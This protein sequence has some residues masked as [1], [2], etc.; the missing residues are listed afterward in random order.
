MQCGPALASR[1]GGAAAQL[2]C[3]RR[4]VDLTGA[5]HS[6]CLSMQPALVKTNCPG[7]LP[8]GDAPG[9]AAGTLRESG[10]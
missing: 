8:A 7:A 4:A 1:G 2:R 5:T 6:F 3:A 9:T 10:C